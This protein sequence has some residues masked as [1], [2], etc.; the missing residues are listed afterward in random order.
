MDP[1][2][3][4]NSVSNHLLRTY[5][6]PYRVY[7]SE[8]LM[9]VLQ[10]HHLAILDLSNF[11]D[12]CKARCGPSCL[13]PAGWRT[14]AIRPRHSTDQQRWR[15]ILRRRALLQQR[16]GQRGAADLDGGG[17]AAAAGREAGEPG[18]RQGDTVGVSFRLVFLV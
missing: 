5:L 18:I 1:P 7:S 9:T 2:N 14:R 3:L 16:S 15:C 17:V 8:H 12:R 4:H 11:P 6:D 10:T 13:T